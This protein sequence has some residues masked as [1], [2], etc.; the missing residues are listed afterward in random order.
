[1]KNIELKAALVKDQ[2][3]TEPFVCHWWHIRPYKKQEFVAVK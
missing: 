1:V 3:V 2:S